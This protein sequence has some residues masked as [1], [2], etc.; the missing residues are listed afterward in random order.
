MRIMS[1]IAR[2]AARNVRAIRPFTLAVGMFILSAC[3]PVPIKQEPIESR[4]AVDI[5]RATALMIESLGGEVV[6]D[7]EDF[8]GSNVPDV[9]PSEDY[10]AR[11]FESSDPGERPKIVFVRLVGIHITDNEM[12]LLHY[13]PDLVGLSVEESGM[14]RL[15]GSSGSDSAC[16]SGQLSQHD[17]K[18]TDAG[19]RQLKGLTQ[20]KRLWLT[21]TGVRG[22]GVAY[23][24]SLPELEVLNLMT[25]L[26][27]NEG[28]AHLKSARK[29]QNLLLSSERIT[30]ES[31]PHL[32][33]IPRL[34]G[35]SIGETSIT[36]A[37]L[38]YL[39]SCELL[40]ELGLGDRQLTKE[41]VEQLKLMPSLRAIYADKSSMPSELE[42]ELRQA[43]P[44]LQIHLGED[45]I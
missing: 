45:R 38:R 37:G 30:D 5:Q 21:A 34:T 17:G 12:M 24:A 40:N 10:V 28:L 11:R 43:R 18:I 29:L 6:Y 42:T 1:R 32:A 22:P 19:L 41:G 39:R 4:G 14:G 25:P 9:R 33:Q 27:E 44:E 16:N 8:G 20:L 2:A 26:L 23:I 35:L 31:V 36:G 7:F 13:L 3:H 15:Q